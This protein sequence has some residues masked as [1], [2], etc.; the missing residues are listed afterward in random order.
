[1]KGR[2]PKFTQAEIDHM[3]AMYQKTGRAYG[4]PQIA[5]LFRTSEATVNK[6]I[7]GTLKARPE[8]SA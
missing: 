8:P 2:P 6:A 7:S 1:M 5:R 4:I 3:R